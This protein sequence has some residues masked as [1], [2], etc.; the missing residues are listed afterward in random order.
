M[1]SGSNACFWLENLKVKNYLGNTG[2]HKWEDNS[3]CYLKEI[4]SEGVNWIQLPLDWIPMIVSC[5]HGNELSD[6]KQSV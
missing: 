6:S 2:I 3:K 5:Q 4:G 1:R